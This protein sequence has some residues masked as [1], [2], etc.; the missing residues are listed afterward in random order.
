MRF[1]HTADWHLGR[2]MRGRSRTAEFEAILGEIVGIARDE[3]VDVVMICG[4]I[5]DS[6][7]P[8]PDAE[9]LLYG[10]LR[11]LARSRIDVVLIAG[12]HDNPRRLQAFGQVG[13]LIGVHVRARPLN[14]AAG[15]I[16]ITRNGQTARIAAAP[17][18]AE[19]RLADALSTLETR[20]VALA[21]YADG[22][23]DLYADLS[24]QFDAGTVNVLAAHVFIDGATVAQVDGSERRL[25]I[26]QTYAVTPAAIPATAQYAALGH[27]HA[28]QRIVDAAAP[29]WYAGSLLQL[30]FGESGQRKSVRIVDIDPGRPATSRDVPL[31]AG[32]HLLEVRGTLDEVLAQGERAGDAY[33]RAVVRLDRPEPGLSARIREHLPGCVEVRV[34]LTRTDAAP[35]EAS[36]VAHLPPHEQFARYYQS[37]HGAA[38]TPELIALF[39]EILDEARPVE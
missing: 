32:Q 27:V 19:G 29:T 16:E 10:V 22:M 15:I 35:T 2:T 31:T 39:R 9:R 5:W 24:A 6:A 23:R 38:P 28:P 26:G 8:P 14:G 33:L 11:E 4:D 20:D 25:H 34:E 21:S 3:G 1:L 18:V 7:A 30:D 12:N 13:E 37:Q 17:W 36:Q